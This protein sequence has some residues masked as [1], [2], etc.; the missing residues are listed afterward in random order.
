M[1]NFT[2]FACYILVVVTL[3]CMSFVFK[4]T[5][6]DY[7]TTLLVAGIVVLLTSIMFLFVLFFMTDD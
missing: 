5:Y 1:G 6:T 4:E 3:V 2:L 7:S